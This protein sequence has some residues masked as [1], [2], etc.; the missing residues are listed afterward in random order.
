M[1]A[2]VLLVGGD[3]FG[4]SA[5]GDVVERSPFPRLGLALVVDQ[6]DGEPARDEGAEGA[7]GLDFREL[8]VIADQ[9]QLP[10]GSFHVL[11]QL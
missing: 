1:D 3:G 4:G 6:L 8:A 7:A 11:E 2:A 5:V 9:H 10:V